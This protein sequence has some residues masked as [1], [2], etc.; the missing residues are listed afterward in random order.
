MV[1]SEGREAGRDEAR[2]PGAALWGELV[3]AAGLR[4]APQH[5]HKSQRTARL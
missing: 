5:L 2:R 1:E 4:A 3:G